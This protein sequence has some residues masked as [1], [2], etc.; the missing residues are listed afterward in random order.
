MITLW[1]PGKEGLILE[2]RFGS[3]LR[4]SSGVKTNP[5]GGQAGL[6]EGSSSSGKLGVGPEKEARTESAQSFTQGGEVPKEEASK[7]RKIW[8]VQTEEELEE[9][10]M[11]TDGTK[12]G[13]EVGLIP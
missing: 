11:A 2:K 4:A 1:R 7:S 10:N 3:H 5:K 8:E 13:E 12:N 9:D 6:L